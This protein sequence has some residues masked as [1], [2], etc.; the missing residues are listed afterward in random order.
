[1]AYLGIKSVGE[2]S[3]FS[4]LVKKAES[5]GI[6]VILDGSEPSVKALSIIVNDDEFAGIRQ[7]SFDIID[8]DNTS[9]SIPSPFTWEM[10]TTSFMKWAETATHGIM[11]DINIALA[12]VVRAMSVN[13][14]DIVRRIS[15]LEKEAVDLLRTD[16]KYAGINLKGLKPAALLHLSMIYG[17]IIHRQKGI[18]RIIWDVITMVVMGKYIPD[19]CRT[20]MFCKH[21]NEGTGRYCKSPLI[22]SFTLPDG[23]TFGE[24]LNEYPD[25]IAKRGKVMTRFITGHIKE[26]DGYHRRF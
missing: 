3:R 13:D 5:M 24:G 4:Q 26:C 22:D 18:E 21:T 1:M 6:H 19:K 11:S 2:I 15:N 9:K 10:D 23:F 8:D 20:C 12:N 17:G 14:F 25:F 7:H 16:C